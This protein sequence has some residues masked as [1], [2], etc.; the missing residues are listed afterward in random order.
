MEL[1]LAL[2]GRLSETIA[3]QEAAI[4]AAMHL[5]ADVTGEQVKQWWRADIRRAGIGDK[6]GLALRNL[7]FPTNGKSLRPAVVVYSA[8]PHIMR[9]LTEPMTIRSEGGAWL[10][11][12]TEN[13]PQ[14]IYGKRVTPDLYERRFGAG[15]LDFVPLVPGRSGLLVDNDLRKRTGKRGGYAPRTERSRSE[16]ESVAMFVLTR[17]VKTKPKLSLP[18]LEARG[19]ALYAEMAEAQLS[20]VLAGDGS[21]A[22]AEA[23]VAGTR[24][25]AR[26]LRRS[27][28]GGRRRR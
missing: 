14:R 4:A 9:G 15:R 8:V 25:G 17:T 28:R 23:F 18:D 24:A 1:R 2:T 6:L 5:A 12:P 20:R 13:A 7:V 19:A 10:A 11:I 3:E 26:E 16:A 21:D 22:E 27:S